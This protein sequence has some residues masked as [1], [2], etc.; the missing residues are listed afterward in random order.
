M[1]LDYA[2]ARENMVENQVR[3]N[4]VTDHAVQDAIR[5]VA[6]ERLCPPTRQ[7]LAY[8]ETEVEYA[9]GYFLMQPRCIAKLLQGVRPRA[10]ERALAIGAP[11]A[12]MVMK[13]IGLAVRLRM[14]PGV[15]APSCV[16]EA[17]VEVVPAELGA[18]DD[19]A[20]FDV[21]VAEGSV[22]HVPE[23]WTGMIGEGGRLGVVEREGPVGRARLYLRGSDGLVAGRTLFDASPHY[24]SG[25]SPQPAF[26]F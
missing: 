10:G 18:I 9:P 19:S 15:E 2:A 13:R 4:D 14:A 11:Y 16:A 24:L 12:A 5:A 22:H 20:P 17:G 8:A 7:H 23:T 6:R 1:T 21:L 26:Q 25:F 3:T